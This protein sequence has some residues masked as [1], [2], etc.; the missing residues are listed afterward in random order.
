MQNICL[1]SGSTMFVLKTDFEGVFFV[2]K[3]IFGNIS[4]DNFEPY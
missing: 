2:V 3:V 1:V 4:K